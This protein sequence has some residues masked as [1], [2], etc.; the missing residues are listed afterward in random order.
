[1]CA[2]TLTLCCPQGV[3]LHEIEFHVSGLPSLHSNSYDSDCFGGIFTYSINIHTS[4]AIHYPHFAMFCMLAWFY[5]S[6]VTQADKEMDGN[7]RDD[8]AL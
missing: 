3:R 2:L 7:I 8:E 1:M 6:A 5:R 4:Y